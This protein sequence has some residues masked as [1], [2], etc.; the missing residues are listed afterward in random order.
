MESPDRVVKKAW[1]PFV[2]IFMAK[3]KGLFSRPVKKEVI[4]SVHRPLLND[5]EGLHCCD[6]RKNS[7]RQ[8]EG[9]L[10]Q[11]LLNDE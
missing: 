2:E 9:L 11:L 4:E 5:D 1:L 6:P 8:V 3:K 7:A 10:L